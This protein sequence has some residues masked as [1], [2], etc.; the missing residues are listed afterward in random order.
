MRLLIVSG[1]SYPS[2]PTTKS[3]QVS[4]HHELK[5][6]PTCPIFRSRTSPIDEADADAGCGRRVYIL[7]EIAERL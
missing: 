6:L 7:G 4:F 2:K 5:V 1:A 3:C